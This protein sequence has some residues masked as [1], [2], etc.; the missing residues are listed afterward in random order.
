MDATPLR[1]IMKDKKFK[2]VWGELQGEAL[3][4]AP[5]GF[6]KEHP[7]IDLIRHKQ[8]IFTR[9]FDDRTVLSPDFLDTVDTTFK[10]IRPYFDFMSMVLTT[11]LNGESLID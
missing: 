6:D 5:K 11:N 1:D 9:N 3:K 7:D 10:A 2:S 8:F 4:T